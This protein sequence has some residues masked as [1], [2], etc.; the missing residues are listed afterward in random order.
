MPP[1]PPTH[2]QPQRPAPL[3]LRGS[4]K[5]PGERLIEL[6]LAACGWASVAVTAGILFTLAGETL[7]FF[8]EVSLGDFLLD[9]Q[10]TPLFADKHFGIWPL[11]S[12]S[13]LIAGIGV[14][15]ALPFGIFAAIYLSEYA[16]PRA[17]GLLKPGLE[18]LAG[19]PTIVYGFFALV[20]VTPLLKLVLPGLGSFNALS[21]G[22]VM[23][24]MITP[25]IASL[26][27]DALRAV[28]AG[29]REAAYGLGARRHVTVWKVVLPAAMSG[30]VTSVLLAVA[31][32]IGE[33]MIVA[34]AAGQQANLTLDPRGPVQ[35]MTAFIVQVSMGDT[36]AGS[37]EYRT[38]FA[39][40][41]ALFLLTFAI[42]A[43]AQRLTKRARA[44]R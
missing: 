4:A 10:W 16:S 12:G 33:T 28:P 39:V 41:S 40:A 25:M 3:S 8:Q 42:N 44:A 6:L 5:G 15:S 2:A 20:V 29:L 21:A 30:V 35:T 34:I 13:V 11:V 26:S 1:Q 31:R 9:T 27:E 38:L 43:F 37:L 14:G 18:I 36:P 17:R 7:A 24:L 19:V 32:A 22:L 23:G